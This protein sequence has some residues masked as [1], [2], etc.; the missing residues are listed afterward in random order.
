MSEGMLRFDVPPWCSE[1][2]NVPLAAV[3]PAVWEEGLSWVMSDVWVVTREGTPS[4][5]WRVLNAAE[6]DDVPVEWATIEQL[7]LWERQCNDITLRGYNN[8]GDA[9]P[10]IEIVAFDSGPWELTV[11]DPSR[12]DTV[13]LRDLGG[14][15]VL[16]NER[17][18]AQ[19]PVDGPDP[20]DSCGACYSGRIEEGERFM[21]DRSVVYGPAEW[22]VVTGNIAPSVLFVRLEASGEEAFLNITGIH[23]NWLCSSPEYWPATG[24]RIRV[25]KVPMPDSDRNRI[26]VVRWEG[27]LE[28]VVGG[29]F[30]TRDL[31]TPPGLG[32]IERAVVVAHRDEDLLVRLEESGRECVLPATSLSYFQDECAKEH[33]PGVGE[34]VRVRRLGVWPGGEVRVS[35]TMFTDKPIIPNPPSFYASRDNRSY[36]SVI[37]YTRTLPEAVVERVRA[38]GDA[39]SARDWDRAEELT[40]H[41]RLG[42]E[43]VDDFMTTYGWPPYTPLPEDFEKDMYAAPLRDGGDWIDC[44][45]WTER[46]RPSDVE[47]SLKITPDPDETDRLDA[48]LVRM[49]AVGFRYPRRCDQRPRPR[50]PAWTVL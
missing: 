33:W 37:A 34:R 1:K 40:S 14:M 10:A 17:A 31:S 22:A 8:P 11:H 21:Y 27:A 39:V 28:G 2:P 20:L 48:S 43:E 7:A 9:E 47:I 4:D 25:C 16:V 30:P 24:E 23:D 46:E 13:M 42:W 45:L 15:W 19:A 5:L 18:E 44:L 3:L 6:N 38:V 49:R 32:P 50:G 26:R 36:E 41:N 35:C 29:W 12:L